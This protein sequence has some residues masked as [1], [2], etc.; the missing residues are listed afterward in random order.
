MNQKFFLIFLF[1][2]ISVPNSY[3]F[4]MGSIVHVGA[5]VLSGNFFGAVVNTIL[6]VKDDVLNYIFGTNKV[7]VPTDNSSE[8]TQE[9]LVNST[10]IA[11][12]LCNGMLLNSTEKADEDIK[13]L[14]RMVD[15]T[16]I[17]QYNTNDKGAIGDIVVKIYGPN[18]IYGYSVF[19]VKVDIYHPD[20]PDVPDPVHINEIIISVNG[21]L[22]KRDITGIDDK[23]EGDSVDYYTLLKTPDDYA[24]T[25]EKL[26]QQGVPITSKIDNIIHSKVSDFEIHVTVKGYEEIWKLVSDG[27]GNEH[28]VHVRNEP[29]SVSTTTTNLVNLV[30]NGYYDVGGMSGSYPSCMVEQYKGKWTP[31]LFEAQGSASNILMRVWSNPCHILNSSASFKGFILGNPNYMSSLYKDFNIV[32][33]KYRVI[34]VR[35]LSNGDYEI[36]SDISGKIGTFNNI[37]EVGTTVTYNGGDDVVGFRDYIIVYGN[38]IRKDGL[39]LPVW[40]IVRPKIT[41]L[42]DIRSNVVSVTK[43]IAPLLSNNKIS[44]SDKLEIKKKLEDTVLQLKNKIATAKVWEAES[45]NVDNGKAVECAKKAQE[46][47][48]NAIDT[49]GKIDLSDAQDIRNKLE[50]AKEYELSGDYWL[51]ACRKYYSGLDDDARIIEEN[52]EK[53]APKSE[54]LLILNDEG[55]VGS[56][57]SYVSHVPGGWVTIIGIILL[58][59]VLSSGNVKHRRRY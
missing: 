50:K 45:N 5:D 26:T 37:R 56:L 27:N 12:R 36:A 11:N 21:D 51:D 35:V 13:A 31:Y 8:I 32:N 3:A 53:V 1:V 38:I 39:H 16:K 6:S 28:W 57:D 10:G 24:G 20:T 41:V 22:W 59:V 33:G 40:M 42:D 34:T 30:G 23:L 19:P 48:Q 14:R 4:D 15:S 52:A 17:I 58:M 55:V 7:S 44:L 47:Y 49:I 29:F 9:E 46:Q 2:F 25:V 18:K 54:G 43:D